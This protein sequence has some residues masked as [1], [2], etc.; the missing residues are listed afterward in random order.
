MH[1]FIGETDIDKYA[2]DTT[3]HASDK[4]SKTVENRLQAGAC[5]FKNYCVKNK[6]SVNANKTDLMILGTR[7]NLA[8]NNK[9]EVY[10]DNQLIE[11]VKNHKLLGVLIDST[12]T[13]DK[14]I[15][16]VCLGVTRKI[17]LLK[18]LSKYVNRN[19][20]YLYYNS[21]ILPYRLWLYDLGSMFKFKY[22]QIDQIAK[23][24]S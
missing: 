8:L 5:N 16:S 22:K 6:M 20:L 12:L 2:D 15:D 24:C 14:Q 11:T 7:Q 4:V 18:M 17:T 10:L 13:W 21:Y 19:S 9:I 23:T 3:V 1:L